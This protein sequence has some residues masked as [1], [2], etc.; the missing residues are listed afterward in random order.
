MNNATLSFC[1]CAFQ[2]YIL[3]GQRKL[4]LYRHLTLLTLLFH[5][6]LRKQDMTWHEFLSLAYHYPRPDY[7][8]PVYSS[9]ES[10]TNILFSSGTTGHLLLLEKP[11]MLMMIYGYHLELVTDL[12]LNAVE[13]LNFASSYIQGS[14]LQLQALATFSTPSIST[15]FVILDE[16]GIP[17]P[18]DQLCEGE[19]GLNPVYMRA[20]DRLLNADH[21]DVYFKGMPFYK[22]M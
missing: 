6:K 3:R 5:I 8:S 10:V 20:T 13:E 16:H 1:S 11:L 21:E 19:V 14:I 7:Y 2:D 4:P 12:L 18:G 17:Y 22:G 15:G 9:P